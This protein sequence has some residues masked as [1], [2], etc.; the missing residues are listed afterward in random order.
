MKLKTQFCFFGTLTI[1][2]AGCTQPG[3]DKMRLSSWVS[4][5]SETALFEQTLQEFE[6]EHPEVVYKFEPIPGNYSEKIQLM[7]GTNTAPDL[8]FLKG[9]VAPS[10]MSFKVLKPLD[11]L[12]AETPD[13]DKDDFY[14]FTLE[15]FQRDG[16]QYGL[17][18]DFNPYVL[19]YNKKLFAAAG[20]DTV[21]SNW[22]ELA[23]MSRQLT[24]DLDGDGRVDEFG[25][26][27]EPSLEMLMPFVYQNDGA[28][29]KEDGSLG[30]TDP[31][32]VEALEFYYGL[33][34]EGVAT[35]PIDHGVPWNGDVFGKEK[36]AMVI[37]GGWLIP[38]LA[39][40]FP[41]VEY[42]VS[43]LPVGKKAATVAFTTAYTI[44]E[45]T[46]FEEEAWTMMNY[47]VGKKGM[48]TWTSKGL[49]L[50]SRRS[51]ALMNGFLEHP[52]YK[53]FM[54]SAE[55]A[56]PIQVEYSERG[57]EEVVVAMQAIFFQDKPPAQAM[58]DIKKRI[59][60]YRLVRN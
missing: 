58:A 50:P 45:S 23:E 10:Y 4:S 15:A 54:E 25:F 16:I 24:K 12:I 33:Y 35:I 32:F 34:K 2:C 60:K 38:F 59:E 18:K 28:F 43:V 57:F 56:R 48:A 29:Q 31:A 55:I 42:G 1:L 19:F 39:D 3:S 21:P 22:Q 51:V 20:L 52:V 53:I 44:P 49:A 13:F 6:D 30:I 37:S 5:P 36:A 41:D 46:R 7:L 40:N 26:A 8:F 11:D 14:P 27:V 17:P 9:I 47:L